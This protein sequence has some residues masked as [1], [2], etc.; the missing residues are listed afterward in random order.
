M[1]KH[2]ESSTESY[3]YIRHETINVKFMPWLMCRKCGLVYL[4]NRFTNWCI[5]VGCD[6]IYHPHYKKM[7]KRL[8]KRTK[9]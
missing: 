2:S 6:N 3:E 4:N 7:L 9:I 8:T 1:Q 5:T